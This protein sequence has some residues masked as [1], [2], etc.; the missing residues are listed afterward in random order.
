MV[1][2]VVMLHF[3]KSSPECTHIEPGMR[4]ALDLGQGGMCLV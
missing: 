4:N 1:M 2:V 3:S